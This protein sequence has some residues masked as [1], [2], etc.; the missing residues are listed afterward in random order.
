MNRQLLS[1]FPSPAERGLV[2]SQRDKTH[3]LSARIA[4]TPFMDAP[5]PLC[6][7]GCNMTYDIFAANHLALVRS[8][9]AQRNWRDA[10]AADRQIATGPARWSSVE[11]LDPSGRRPP[12][13][14][15]D[16]FVE[17]G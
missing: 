15:P 7:R 3:L 6:V 2:L 9:A 14:E 12:T 8:P 13:R 11:G 16:C 1:P 17:G 4:A 10:A 5:Q